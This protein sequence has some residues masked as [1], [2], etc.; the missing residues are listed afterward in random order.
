M[1]YDKIDSS[2]GIDV[3]KNNNSK[4]YMVCYYWFLNHGLKFEDSVCNGCHHFTIL[5]LNFSDIAI[6]IVKN[7]DYSCIIY[8]ISNS[9]E[10]NLLKN[11]V[12]HDRRFM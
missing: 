6:I 2:K 9:D 11:S 4:E 3:A 12:L 8:N 1:Y 10:I 7:V 5:C